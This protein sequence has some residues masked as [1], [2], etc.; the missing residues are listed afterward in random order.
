MGKIAAKF[1][2]GGQHRLS[3]DSGQ[4]ACAGTSVLGVP[5]E[6][7]E[8]KRGEGVG[9]GAWL[10][11][12]LG[13]AP[14]R[15]RPRAL[16]KPRGLAAKG[17]PGPT[18]WRVPLPPKPG[19]QRTSAMRRPKHHAAEAAADAG[20]RRRPL[21]LGAGPAS[22]RPATLPGG[23]AASPQPVSSPESRAAESRGRPRPQP[24]PSAER[25]RPRGLRREG[26]AAAAR[27]RERRGRPSR[28]PSGPGPALSVKAAVALKRAFVVA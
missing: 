28:G 25:K 4:R 24:P 19:A 26:A 6:L 13:P 14:L 12:G 2:F 8:G 20:G 17:A 15:R 1:Q 27:G 5:G 11:I 10:P 9:P 21:T 23:A 18:K 22:E 3:P 16:R 7:L